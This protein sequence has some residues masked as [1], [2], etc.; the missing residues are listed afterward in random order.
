M[1]PTDLFAL[2]RAEW[3]AFAADIGEPA[4][5]GE[6]IHRWMHVDLAGSFDEM[7]NLSKPLRA[8]LTERFGAA[9]APP[10]I[11]Q[12]GDRGTTVKA[13][14]RFDGGALAEA[15]LM[16]YDDRATVC[17]SSQAGCGMG[18]P[19]C[20]TGQMGLLRNLSPGEIVS[21]V[22]WAARTLRGLDL[23]E[24][25]TRRLS[26]VVFMGMGEPLA[27]FDRVWESVE[28]IHDSEGFNLSARGITI[29]T[30][31]VLPG[32][33]RL[34]AA[35]LPVTLALSLH[36]PNDELRSTLV[37]LNERYPI[38]ALLAAAREHRNA[39]GRRVSIE[40]A[41]IGGV[42]DSDDHARELARLLRGDD[43][44]V[45]LIPLNPTPGFEG[46]GSPLKQI[47]R[48]QSLLESGGINAT[49]RRNRGTDIDAACGQL[50][51]RAVAA[52]A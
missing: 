44:H 21:Q 40:Y 23:P 38:K 35:G 18:C 19:F 3:R 30:V 2:T 43:F 49:V 20:A 24:D 37:P 48:F 31:G 1:N 46:P 27:N 8:G 11:V 50:G 7:T 16:A 32:M 14:F 33:R 47:E 25:W 39:H 22:L 13:L 17:I 41:M 45:N 6:Q 15:V 10:A 26:N 36:A 5:R 12:T 42:N 4:F 9:F 34:A 52:G 28:R 29:S 51:A